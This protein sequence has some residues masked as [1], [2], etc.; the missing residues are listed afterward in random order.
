MAD[1]VTQC[2]TESAAVRQIL[3]GIKAAKLNDKYE[4]KGQPTL[5]YL[6]KP[7]RSCCSSTLGGRPPTNNFL[8]LTSLP[9]VYRKQHPTANNKTRQICLHLW[10]IL[11]FRTVKCVQTHAHCYQQCQHYQLIYTC[12]QK[13]ARLMIKTDVLLI[14]TLINLNWDKKYDVLYWQKT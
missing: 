1:N 11:R 14:K 6:L 12:Q 9:P 13:A 8:R 4:E 3:L 10:A 7:S 2:I 5:P